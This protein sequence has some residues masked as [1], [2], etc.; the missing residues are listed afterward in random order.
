MAESQTRRGVSFAEALKSF[1]G[2]LRGSKKAAS[3]VASYQSD[4]RL[5]EEF[6]HQRLSRK[7]QVL[8]SDLQLADLKRYSEYLRSQGFHDNTRRRRLLTVRRLFTFLKRRGR[9]EIDLGRRIPAPHKVEKVPKVAHAGELIASVEALPRESLV[10][11]RNRVL[12]WFLLETGCLVSEA[13]K[14]RFDQWSTQPFRVQ[15]T[16]KNERLVPISAELYR[17]AKSLHR[18]AGSPAFL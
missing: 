5:F 10:Q 9:L 18:R 6:V 4:L 8:V 12:L 14:T 11:E 7:R 1:H 16:G 2:Y 15:F 3:T 13:A 17:A